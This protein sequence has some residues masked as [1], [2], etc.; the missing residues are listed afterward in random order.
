[1]LSQSVISSLGL[2][3]S[4][5]LAGLTIYT[6]RRG[7]KVAFLQSPPTKALSV[8]Q[9]AWQRNFRWGMSLWRALTQIERENYQRVCDLA[10]LCML[11]HNLWLSCYLSGNTRLVET[12][13]CQFKI[14]LRLPPPL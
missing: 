2:N 12:L 4:G 6:T 14:P 5:D 8:W 7:R 10:S 3:V 13:S 1:M 11:G 9:L